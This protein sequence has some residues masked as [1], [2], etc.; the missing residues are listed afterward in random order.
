MHWLARNNWQKMEIAGFT[1]DVA[2]RTDVGRTRANNEDSLLSVVPEDG[3][4]LR[5]K[6]ALFVVSDGIGG[7][8][9]GKVASA[10]AVQTVR[11]SFYSSLQEDDIPTALRDA[12]QAA[13]IAIRQASAPRHE[14]GATC[15]A[16]VVRDQTLTV[17]NVGDSRAYVLHNGQLRQITHDHSLVAQLVECGAT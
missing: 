6:G 14:L 9:V 17:A 7:R 16:V 8:N 15:V 4:A 3:Q 13:N 5:E 2:Q 10:L 1:L 12:F 11:E